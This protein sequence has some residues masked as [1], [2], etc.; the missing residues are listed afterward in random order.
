[1]ALLWIEGFESFGT[2]N[3]TAPVGLQ[4]KYDNGVADSSFSVQAG[5][6]S[7]QSMRLPNGTA[8]LGKDLNKAGSST[9]IMGFGLHVDALTNPVQLIHFMDSAGSFHQGGLELLANGTWKYYRGGTIA[10][11]GTLLGTSSGSAVTAGVWCY[12]EIKVKFHSSTG[13]VDIW[14]DGVNVLSLTGQNTQQSSNAFA[15]GFNI[16]GA[17]AMNDHTQYDDIYVLD[18]TGSVNNAR[19]GPRVVKMIVPASDAGTN[20]F[21]TDSGSNH[22]DRLTDNP[23]DTTSYVEDDT[24]GHKELV[25]MG[26]LNLATV[27]G[28]QLNSVVAVTGNTIRTVKNT[29]HTSGGT[30]SDDSGRTVADSNYQTHSRVVETNPETSA[31]WNQTQINAAQFGVKVG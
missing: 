12:V 8:I 27:A 25:G 28:I 4:Q 10:S 30:D 1:M 26:S 13:T 16:V 29:L 17:G 7:G 20:Q 31:L 3:G 21:T 19:L 18:D 23:R 22:W 24:T 9:L 5:R 14:V 6:I 15:T 2:S 11:V